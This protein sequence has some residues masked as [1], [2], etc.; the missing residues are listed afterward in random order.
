MIICH[1]AM[2]VAVP[3]DGIRSVKCE[4]LLAVIRSAAAQHPQLRDAAFDLFRLKP[5]NLSDGA[6]PQ[7]AE[8]ALL[9]DAPKNKIGFLA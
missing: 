9:E 2:E 8:V 7:Q 1:F 3:E 5:Q 4:D 6:P